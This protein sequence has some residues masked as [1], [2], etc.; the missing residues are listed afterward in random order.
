MDKQERD[1]KSKHG[2]GACCRGDRN[3]QPLP[4]GL[5][6]EACKEFTKRLRQTQDAGHRRKGE[7]QAHTGCGVWIDQK[8]QR[9]GNS[10]RGRRIVLSSDKRSKQQKALH[11]SRADGRGRRAGSQHK[12]PDQRKADQRTFASL[13]Q[14]LLKHPDEESY[15]H[16]RYRHDVHEPRPG[17]SHKQRIV[18]IEIAL[19]PQHQRF[20]KSRGISGKDAVP[21]RGN[22]VVQSGGRSAKIKAAMG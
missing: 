19:V 11:D 8:N 14:Q 3:T 13:P 21:H 17:H 20:H 16:P 15:M 5:G 10:Q 7:L 22:R 18:L 4:P 6:E 1:G 2:E 12:K 9:K